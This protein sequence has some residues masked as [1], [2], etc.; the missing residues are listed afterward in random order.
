[1]DSRTKHPW[2]KRSPKHWAYYQQ[3]PLS[4]LWPLLAAVFCLFF[5]IGFV[6][7]LLAGA[8]MPYLLVL[9]LGAYCG[10]LAMLAIV[11]VARLPYIF[12]L[13]PVILETITFTIIRAVRHFLDTYFHLQPVSRDAGIRFAAIGIMVVIIASYT[14]FI[15]F[16]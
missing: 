16:I 6:D 14:F 4:R 11:V 7:D 13:I 12:L 5:F 3:M 1:M 2:Y 10:T 15:H 9:V 8:Q